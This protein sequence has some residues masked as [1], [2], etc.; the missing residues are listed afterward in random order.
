MFL[1]H[2]RTTLVI[3]TQL[4]L[5]GAKHKRWL[6]PCNRSSWRKNCQFTDQKKKCLIHLS[7]VSINPVHSRV[8]LMCGN[9]VTFHTFHTYVPESWKLHDSQNWHCQFWLWRLWQR[10]QLVTVTKETPKKL[11]SKCP[12][13]VCLLAYQEA[14]SRSYMSTNDL[15]AF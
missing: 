12:E 2:Q 10:V 11:Y 7:L 9:Y 6:S 15:H 14:S 13:K 3:G 4:H 8:A 5:A 1:V